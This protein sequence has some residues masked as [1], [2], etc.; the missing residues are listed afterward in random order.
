M[1]EKRL[2][3]LRC[4]R[5]YLS[6]CCCTDAGGLCRQAISIPVAHNHL[7][8]LTNHGNSAVMVDAIDFWEGAQTG[9]PGGIGEEGSCA[10]WRAAIMPSSEGLGA[11]ALAK[12]QG[13]CKTCGVYLR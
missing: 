7:P 11:V 3:R 8:S 5:C 9:A 1:L 6:Q 13:S 4:R 12:R 10:R 2:E